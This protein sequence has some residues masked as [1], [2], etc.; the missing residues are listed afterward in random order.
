MLYFYFYIAFLV[1]TILMM[2]QNLMIGVV[3]DKK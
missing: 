1:C 2:T 3:G